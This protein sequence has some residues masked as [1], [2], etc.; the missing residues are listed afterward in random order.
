MSATIRP[1]RWLSSPHGAIALIDAILAIP[2]ALRAWPM[3]AEWL[4]VAA[5]LEVRGYGQ[6][7]A[8]QIAGRALQRHH[9]RHHR[10]QQANGGAL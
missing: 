1:R 6:V 10:R 2:P 5:Q 3:F 7:R 8:L 4:A 9:R